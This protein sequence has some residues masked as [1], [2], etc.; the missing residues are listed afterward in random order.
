MSQPLVSVVIPTIDSRKHYLKLA[1]HSVKTQTYKNWELIIIRNKPGQIA[2]NEGIR[3]ASGKYIAFLDDDDTWCP[4]KLEKQVAM[5][6]E[7]PHAS[8]CICWMNDYRSGKLYV[9]KPE[10]YISHSDILSGWCLSS[11]SSYLCRSKDLALLWQ[12]DGY[13]FDPKYVSGQEYNVAMRI[14]RWSHVI[15][16]QEALANQFASVGQISNDWK[17]KIRGKF[18]MVMDM[19]DELG[20][21]RSLKHLGVI[22]L[23]FAGYFLGN[24]Q[25]EIIDW[26]KDVR[27]HRW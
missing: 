8:I 5:M 9:N 14:T 6:E 12:E 23:F 3:K 1:I 4:E 10:T 2:R 25:R 11:T 21:K 18:I 7:Y 27:H 22:P 24:K 16:V 13:V 17:K 20:W 26:L 15:C 19:R